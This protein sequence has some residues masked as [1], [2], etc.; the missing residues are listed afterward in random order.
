MAVRCEYQT[1]T[2]ITGRYAFGWHAAAPSCLLAELTKEAEG[3]GEGAGDVQGKNQAPVVLERTC[4][5]VSSMVA[6]A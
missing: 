2:V 1:M 5:P 6:L 4:K 3:A